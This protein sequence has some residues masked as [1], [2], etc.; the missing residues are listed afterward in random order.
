MCEKLY[1]IMLY[2]GETWATSVDIMGDLERAEI[3]MP[4]LM[5][6]F[7][8]QTHECRYAEQIWYRVYWRCCEK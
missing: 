7:A 4:R 8:R 3:R 6:Q 1:A 2:N 5:C